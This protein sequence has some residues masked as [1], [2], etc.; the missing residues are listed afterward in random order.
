[1]KK[2]I[3]INF[4]RTDDTARVPTFSTAGAAAAD[5]YA[6]NARNITIPVGA[7]MWIATGIKLEIPEGFCAQVCSRSGLA[8]NGIY[9][10]NTAGLIDSDFRGEI[11]VLLAN[12][13]EQPFVVQK[14]DR[15]AQLLFKE[16]E[17]PYFTLVEKLEDT[18]RGENGFGSTGVRDE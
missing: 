1:M 6:N 18:D 17:R 4:T 7:R 5:V 3:N 10:A 13:G 14:Y 11:K 9:V 12:S 15:V 2:I 8:S 16:Y